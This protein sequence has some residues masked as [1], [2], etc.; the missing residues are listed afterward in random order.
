MV[1]GLLQ[2][3]AGSAPSSSVGSTNAKLPY[4]Q[5][6]KKGYQAGLKYG[7]GPAGYAAGMQLADAKAREMRYMAMAALYAKAHNYRD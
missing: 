7:N 3:L 1:S 4:E 5:G 2:M 6:F